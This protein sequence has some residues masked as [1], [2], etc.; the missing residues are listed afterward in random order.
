MRNNHRKHPVLMNDESSL[1]EQADEH[2]DRQEVDKHKQSRRASIGRSK[3][4]GSTNREHG[5]QNSGPVVLWTGCTKARRDRKENASIR[6]QFNC[7]DDD[8]AT[9]H[10]GDG[11]DKSGSN[12]TIAGDI[13]MPFTSAFV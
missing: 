9:A 8:D 2:Q 1:D 11:R 4:R 3:A 6:V 12:L 10:G 7:H 13:K 5:V